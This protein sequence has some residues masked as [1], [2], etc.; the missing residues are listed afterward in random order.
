MSLKVSVLLQ[1]A[2]L[3]KEEFVRQHTKPC[4]ILEPFG[5]HRS[6]QVQTPS[7]PVN[8]TTFEPTRVLDA[9]ESARELA[10]LQQLINPNARVEWMAKSDRN[11]FSSLITMGRARNNDVVVA[12]PTVSKVHVIFTEIEDRWSVMD[13]ASSNGTFLNEHQLTPKTKAPIRDGDALRLGPDVSCRFFDPASLWDYLQL[14]R[15]RV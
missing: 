3:P 15:G 5:E 6:S 11:P 9:H 2:D 14:L 13:D 7:G 12:T 10:R 1:E 8:S 4:L